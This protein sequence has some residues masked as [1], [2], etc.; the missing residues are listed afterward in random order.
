[1]TK[2]P[3][4]GDLISIDGGY[5]GMVVGFMRATNDY[6][7]LIPYASPATQSQNNCIIGM[8]MGN[9]WKYD[10]TR[11]CPKQRWEV[12]VPSAF[13]GKSIWMERRKFEVICEV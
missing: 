10:Y 2:D 6:L 5:A 1:M 12:V 4:C 7:K 3:K 9:V 13:D 8:C 11:D